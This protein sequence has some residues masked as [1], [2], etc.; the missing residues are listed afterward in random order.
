MQ[1]SWFYTFTNNGIVSSSPAIPTLLP[2]I[3]SVSLF[4]LWF[5]LLFA[6]IKQWT[7]KGLCAYSTKIFKSNFC[8]RVIFSMVMKIVAMWHTKL[9]AYLNKHISHITL[10]NTEWFKCRSL[11][12]FKPMKATDIF[13]LMQIVVWTTWYTRCTS[14]PLMFFGW[15]LCSTFLEDP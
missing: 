12:F 7:F 15:R 10:S 3:W 9:P 13:T 14:I 5:Y 8:V 4:Y 1:E 2:H 11:F 6:V